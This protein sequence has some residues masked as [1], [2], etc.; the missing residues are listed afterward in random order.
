MKVRK[1][2]QSVD[3]SVVLKRGNKNF[4]RRGYGDK[5]WNSDR[6]N[7]HSELAPTG[8]IASTYTD[9][10]TRQYSRSQEI[11]ADRSLTGSARACQIQRR[12]LAA[13]RWTENW[14]PAGGIRERIEG[15][16][17][18]CNAIRIIIQTN[19]NSQR[20]KHYPKTTQGQ[21]HGSSC[22]CIRAWPSWTQIGVEALGPVKAGPPSVGEFQRRRQEGGG[23]GGVPP[24]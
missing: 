2:D 14:V 15:D 4:G 13:N 8:D 1:D 11:P 6:R 22:I 5:I 3:A 10:K 19:Q 23:W 21:T 20:L 12:M 16:D 24:L 7:G 18:A 17:G 9:T